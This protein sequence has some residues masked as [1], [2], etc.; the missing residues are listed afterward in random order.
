MMGRLAS[1]WIAILWL[2]Q[3]ARHHR[4]CSATEAHWYQTGTR[5]EDPRPEPDIEWP[6]RAADPKAA[7]SLRGAIVT[8]RTPSS[9]IRAADHGEAAQ[10]HQP[11][12]LLPRAVRERMGTL[13]R[14]GRHTVTTQQCRIHRQPLS[15]HS[16][17]GCDAVT[18]GRRQGVTRQQLQAFAQVSRSRNQGARPRRRSSACGA[19]SISGS[20]RGPS[21]LGASAA[22]HRR[23]WRAKCQQ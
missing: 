2:Q 4:Q 14:C 20:G 18:A 7:A 8:S 17:A 19:R 10:G 9:P 5:A 12:W 21:A 22:L 23:W 1:G 6:G 11:T 13:L 16:F 3:G 15:R